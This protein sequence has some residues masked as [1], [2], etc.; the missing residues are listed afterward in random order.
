LEEERRRLG[1]PCQRAGVPSYQ[2]P[3]LST[4]DGLEAGSSRV[5]RL[6]VTITEIEAR[7]LFVR[8]FR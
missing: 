5:R 1:K 2:E 7:C 3:E 8:M 6:S 4:T